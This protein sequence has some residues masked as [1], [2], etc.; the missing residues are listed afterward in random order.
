MGLYYSV[1]GYARV[2]YVGVSTPHYY[3]ETAHAIGEIWRAKVKNCAGAKFVRRK[4][5]IMSYLAITASLRYV[6]TARTSA[7]SLTNTLTR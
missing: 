6:R 4:P 7:N 3:Q 5:Y 1:Y 2:R